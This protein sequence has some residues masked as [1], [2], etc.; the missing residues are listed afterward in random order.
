MAKVHLGLGSNL[1]NRR[2]NL[3]AAFAGLAK[4]PAT[5]LAKK[6]GLF[7]TA[8]VG[9]PEGQGAF[10]NSACIVETELAPDELLSEIHRLERS[11]GRRRESEARWGPRTIDIDI[12]LWENLVRDD[13]RLTLPH[14]RLAEREFAL[15]PLAE[16]D[17]EARHPLLGLTARELL[18]RIESDT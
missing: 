8:P 16:I 11:L 17:P 1:G 14:P 18:E 12:L 6:A 2:E 13:A 9:G 4:L 7:E 5:R 10:L 15:A 3:E